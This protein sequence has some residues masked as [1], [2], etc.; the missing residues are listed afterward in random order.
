MIR[1]NIT[2]QLQLAQGYTK[3]YINTTIQPNVI[4][5][6]YGASGAGKT[7][8]LKIL[9]GLIQPEHGSIEVNGVT[10]LDPSRRICLPPQQRSIGFVFQDYALFPHMT[11]KQNLQYAAGKQGDKQYME[12]LLHLVKMETFIN[13]Q[14]S[15]LSGGQQQR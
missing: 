5:A 15:Q 2:K 7:T 9:A 12:E 8:L 3:L 6:I 1:I 13:A 10:W 14:P 4:T 11:V